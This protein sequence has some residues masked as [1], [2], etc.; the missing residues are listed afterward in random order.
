[1]F[2]EQYIILEYLNE[3]DQYNICKIINGIEITTFTIK[4]ENEN[5]NKINDC[6][7]IKFTKLKTLNSHWNKTITDNGI[8]HMK[9]L[10]ELKRT[11][12]LRHTLDLTG[13]DTITDNGIE[14]INLLSELKRT[15]RLRHTLKLKNNKNITD[16]GIKHM[17]LHTLDL[18]GNNT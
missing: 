12:R 11:S 3:D 5:E 16:N 7:L 10:R 15:S 8:K 4:Y 6:D 18:T 2:P 14:H 13:N 17:K 9:L 1:M